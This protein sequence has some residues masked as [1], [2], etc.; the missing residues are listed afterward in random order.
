MI[1]LVPSIYDYLDNLEAIL[2]KKKHDIQYTQSDA[3]N[4]LFQILR[5]LWWAEGRGGM[6]ERISD[7][8]LLLLRM[9]D[10]GP[11]TRDLPIEARVHQLVVTRN[12]HGA[13]EDTG[14]HTEMITVTKMS[15]W[16]EEIKEDDRS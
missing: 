2:M 9:C 15:L 4:Y 6:R 16:C 8:I 3:G 13:L 11:E 7:R 1:L 10:Q 5:E 14:D 12:W